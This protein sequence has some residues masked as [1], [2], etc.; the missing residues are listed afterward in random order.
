MNAR[1]GTAIYV[2]V[3]ILSGCFSERLERRLRDEEGRRGKVGLLRALE[4]RQRAQAVAHT[5]S[6][7]AGGPCDIGWSADEPFTLI[8]E[9][10]ID[11]IS[12]RWSRRWREQG[13][14]EQDHLG[15]WRVEGLARFDDAGL[16]PDQSRRFEV[17]ADDEGFWEVLGPEV[18]ARYEAQGAAHDGW[19]SEFIGRFAGLLE[20]IGPGWSPADEGQWVPGEERP[21]CGPGRVRDA[22]AWRAIL[23]SRSARREADVHRKD[24]NGARCRHLN[25]SYELRQGAS[26]E[27]SYLECLGPT[28]G[29]LKRPVVQE[30]IQVGGDDHRA[31]LLKR[32]E[33]W[34]EA[35]IVEAS[36]ASKN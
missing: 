1:I 24:K 12:H 28:P 33:N 5:I 31:R 7:H 3:L 10:E 25:A 17:F 20:L 29:R 19:R 26:L 2:G 9:L 8:F 14:F 34:I 22:G 15:Q 16:A 13:R 35:G 30:V 32:V 36:E 23:G 27:L 18:M 21:N 4:V 11:V 6:L